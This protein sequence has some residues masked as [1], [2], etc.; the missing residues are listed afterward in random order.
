MIKPD[1]GK[2]IFLSNDIINNLSAY[3]VK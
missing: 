3:K 1:N 2:P